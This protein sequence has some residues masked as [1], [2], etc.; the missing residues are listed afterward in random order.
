MYVHNKMMVF[1]VLKRELK[2][3]EREKKKMID[4]DHVLLWAVP[5]LVTAL[6]YGFYPE[7]NDHIHVINRDR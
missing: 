6:W 4:N 1:D 3:R 5:I 7:M 2:E